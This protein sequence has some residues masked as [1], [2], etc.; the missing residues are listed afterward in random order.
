MWRNN[1]ADAF[2]HSQPMLNGSTN[3]NMELSVSGAMLKG[4]A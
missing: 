2:S 3:T 4:E 1:D